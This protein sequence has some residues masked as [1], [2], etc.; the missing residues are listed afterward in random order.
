MI[1]YHKSAVFTPHNQSRIPL[2]L[3]RA[4]DIIDGLKCIL[5]RMKFF[6][7]NVKNVKVV[8]EYARKIKLD[9]ATKMVNVFC[10]FVKMATKELSVTSVKKII[11]CRPAVSSIQ[12]P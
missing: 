12:L 1:Y 9:H 8:K 4:R 6:F 10:A 2:T 3:P 11:G 5:V 7:Q